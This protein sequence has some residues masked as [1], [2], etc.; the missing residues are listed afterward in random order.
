MLHSGSN[1]VA[2]F[3]SSISVVL[4]EVETRALCHD[5]RDYDLFSLF[6]QV[7][8]ANMQE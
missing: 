5:K 3:I 7:L 8:L 2:Q 4:L 6:L 1:L